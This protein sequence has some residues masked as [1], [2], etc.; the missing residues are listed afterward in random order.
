MKVVQEAIVSDEN[1]C[2]ESADIGTVTVE[3]PATTANLGPGFDS[4]GMALDVLDR[5][6][7]SKRMDGSSDLID[8]VGAGADSLPRDE[9]H[10]VLGTIRQLYRDSSFDFGPLHLSCVNRIPHGQGLGSSASAIVSALLAGKTFAAVQG[11]DVSNIDVFQIASD[12]EGHPDNVAPC[13]FGGMNV[14]WEEAGQWNLAQLQPHADIRV[15]LAVPDAVLS[16]RTARDLIPAMIPHQDAVRNS[17]RTAL[18]VHAFTSDPTL[19]LPATE[20]FLH[21]KYRRDA[22]PRTYRF[23]QDLRARGLAAAVSGAGPAV[24][25]FST[26]DPSGVLAEVTQKDPHGFHITHTAINMTGARVIG[27]A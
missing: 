18:L 5:V 24:I 27:A 9:S 3:V 20:D 13:V 16:T 19:L 8:V 12:M 10:L 11:A 17:A 2:Q 26:S 21:Q 14:S 6:S 1:G 22:Y 4:I 25:I 7:L 23:V 15:T